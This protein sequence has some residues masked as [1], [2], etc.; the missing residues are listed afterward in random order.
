MRAVLVTSVAFGTTSNSLLVKVLQPVI[1]I[2]D[3]E[4]MMSRVLCWPVMQPGNSITYL[5]RS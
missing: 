4:F 1:Q 2:L 3:T 5:P